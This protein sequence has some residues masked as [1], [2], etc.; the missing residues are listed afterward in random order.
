MK[1]VLAVVLCGGAG[2]RLFPLTATMAKPAISLLG[3][4]R[5]VDIP[6]TNCLRA[7]LNRIFVLTQFNSAG[8]HRHIAET[9]RF[10]AFDNRFVSILAAEQ[11]PASSDWYQGTADAV[12]QVLHHL[13]QYPAEHILVLSGDQLYDMDY[14]KLLRHHEA[15]GADVT[16]ATT[17]VTAEDAVGFGIMRT[18][19]DHV[20]T[21]FHEKPARPALAALESPV[22]EALAAA[23]RHYLASTGIYMFRREALRA[24]LLGDPHRHDFGHD[25]IP[26]ALANLKVVS[27]PFDGY[28]SD[29][30]SVRSYHTANLAMTEPEPAFD[31]YRS[32]TYM[33][34][35]TEALPP[36]KVLGSLVH[37]AI[38]CEGARVTNARI[39]RSVLGLRAIVGERSTL[40][41]T[42]MMGAE[43]YDN[44]PVAGLRAVQGPDQP[45]VGRACYIEQ[46]VLDANVRIGDGTVIANQDNVQEGEGENYYIRDGIIV[47][48]RNAN[49]APGSVIGVSNLPI[50]INRL[51]AEPARTIVPPIGVGMPM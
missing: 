45:G 46:A 12:R 11:T 51:A 34:T 10:D 8:L 26:E 7:E 39:Y 37:D 44:G 30:G 35:R 36:A 25:I 38:I 1:N 50:H 42:V 20:I 19:A 49:I 48:P 3:K 14:R 18:D 22:T 5:L 43:Y 28:W 21:V 2:K 41:N 13:D 27:F 6:I 47:I 17:P 15:T 29:V 4:Y 31:F 33:R 16:V 23:G 24:L 32:C 9:Y 40:R